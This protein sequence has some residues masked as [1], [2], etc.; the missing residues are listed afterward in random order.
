MQ[1]REF[2]YKPVMG[3]DRSV[4]ETDQKVNWRAGPWIRE[5][6][7]LCSDHLMSRRNAGQKICWISDIFER[8]PKQQIFFL[9]V[10]SFHIQNFKLTGTFK[11]FAAAKKNY[12]QGQPSAFLPLIYVNRHCLD[13][14]QTCFLFFLSM[15]LN[16]ISQSPLKLAPKN[17]G[18]GSGQHCQAWSSTVLSSL[19]ARCRG[20]RS[21][22]RVMED[23]RI[24]MSGAQR[25]AWRRASLLMPSLKGT[26]TGL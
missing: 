11:G 1:T 20:A 22:P 7:L 24:S 15:Q 13:A 10:N 6:L 17:V 23:G 19:P 16:Y 21:T 3:P 26:C 8:T 25:T 5:K 12:N 18:E 2:K 14:H 9:S 4:S